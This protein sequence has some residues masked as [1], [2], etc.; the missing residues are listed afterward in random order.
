MIVVSAVKLREKIALADWALYP[1]KRGL[2]F[3]H[4]TMIV[5]SSEGD[6]WPSEAGFCF[7][8]NIS[9]LQR[10]YEL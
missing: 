10:L 2:S 7:I 1:T 6:T 4:W 9:S 3:V 8:L 5:N